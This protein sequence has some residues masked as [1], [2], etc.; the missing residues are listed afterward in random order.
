MGKCAPQ[1]FLNFTS[2]CIQALRA[3]VQTVGVNP[4]EAVGRKTSGTASRA[5]LQIEWTYDPASQTLTIQSVASPFYAPC[6]LITAQIETWVSACYPSRP[7]ESSPPQ[8]DT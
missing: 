7:Q 8:Q 2:E 4:E 6:T 5:G 1:T 3:K